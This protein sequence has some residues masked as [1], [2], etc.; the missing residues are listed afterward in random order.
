VLTETDA[1]GRVRSFVYNARGELTREDHPDFG[2]GG[3][4]YF[5][6]NNG[7]RTRVNRNGANEWYGLDN[8]DKLLWTN[9]AA[10]AAL[11]RCRP[12]AAG[13]RATGPGSRPG[14]RRAG[15]GR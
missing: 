4:Q 13:H 1:G 10:N 6:D 7:N 14:L 11:C 12:G 8:A 15:R 3:I 2:V 9:T 5:Y